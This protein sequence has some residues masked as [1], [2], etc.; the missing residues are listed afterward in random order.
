MNINTNINLNLNLN[1]NLNMN[2]KR[3]YQATNPSFRF[4]VPYQV[5]ACN[6]SHNSCFWFGICPDVE[7]TILWWYKGT[8]LTRKR[9]PLGPYR[10][11]MPRVLGGWVVSYERGT[12]VRVIGTAQSRVRDLHRSVSSLL[13][14]VGLRVATR[15]DKR[16]I[17][18]DVRQLH[19]ALIL[20][21]SGFGCEVGF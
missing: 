8:S 17:V 19:R 2:L 18:E 6:F 12:P 3:V 1:L 10:R 9:T 7:K 14:C 13:L 21:L 16:G 5:V 15:G 20:L 4:R 11:P